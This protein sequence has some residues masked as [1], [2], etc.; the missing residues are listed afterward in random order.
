[1]DDFFIDLMT[2]TCPITGK[3]RCAFSAGLEYDQSNKKA[4]G[5]QKEAWYTNPV[6]H[7]MQK[8]L[9]DDPFFW[10]VVLV[11]KFSQSAFW[12]TERKHKLV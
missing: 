6:S 4:V 11:H 2:Y 3:K 8:Y 1:M 7:S 9:K 5:V 10:G 12:P